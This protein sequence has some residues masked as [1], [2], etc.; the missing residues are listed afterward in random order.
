MVRLVFRHYTQVLRSICTSESL[1]AST[2]V[3]PGFALLRHSSPSFGSQHLRSN[4]NLLSKTHDRSMVQATLTAALPPH[5]ARRQ[6]A[7][8]SFRARVCH[9]NTRAYVRLLGPCFKTGRLT[10]FCQH[11]RD[12]S[13]RAGS[14]VG[15]RTLPGSRRS[16]APEHTLS[17]GRQFL[18][19]PRGARRQVITSTAPEKT[20][21]RSPPCC[22]SPAR[23]TDADRQLPHKPRA[24]PPSTA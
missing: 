20:S 22:H 3:S 19:H 18:S 7:S 9:P 4:S 6:T 12:P 10:P 16:T 11:P 2:R 15:Q 24:F 21:R 8:L 13:D 1:R 14:R 17:S 23:P 5:G